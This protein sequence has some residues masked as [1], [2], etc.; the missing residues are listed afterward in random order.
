MSNVIKF[1]PRKSQHAWALGLR[2]EVGK[3]YKAA[4]AQTGQIEITEVQKSI[5]K[6]SQRVKIL[7]ISLSVPGTLFRHHRTGRVRSRFFCPCFF[8]ETLMQIV[9][10][11]I[12]LYR[13][14]N[15]P[16]ERNSCHVK[17]LERNLFDRS[18]KLFLEADLSPRPKKQT[19]HVVDFF[20]FFE[21][22]NLKSVTA[23]SSCVV[24]FVVWTFRLLMIFCGILWYFDIMKSL[25]TLCVTSCQA[26]TSKKRTAFWPQA[27]ISVSVKEWTS[28]CP[29]LPLNV[30][31]FFLCEIH[32]ES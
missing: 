21:W 18:R 15:L 22:T 19:E 3:F 7:K 5:P 17:K 10:V 9:L 20:L 6:S 13:F 25:E 1:A 4:K 14:S 12:L 24:V 30:K 23:T 11:K 27:Q 31:A 26:W 32:L 29:L 2:Y 8:S 16:Q 28:S